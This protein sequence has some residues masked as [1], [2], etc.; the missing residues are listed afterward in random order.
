LEHLAIKILKKIKRN[1]KVHEW[2]VPLLINS[3]QIIVIAVGFL[4]FL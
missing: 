3:F 1:R 2:E 4:I